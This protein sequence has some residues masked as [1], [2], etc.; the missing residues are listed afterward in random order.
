MP[1]A[2]RY[3]EET[4]EVTFTLTEDDVRDLRAGLMVGDEQGMTSP[5]VRGHSVKQWIENGLSV[6]Y[7]RN[8]MQLMGYLGFL[9]L[10]SADEHVVGLIHDLNEAVMHWYG[11][12]SDDDQT[13]NDL[14]LIDMARDMIDGLEDM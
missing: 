2:I 10:S 9:V 3:N 14:E 6:K 13:V 5:E 7:V 8:H 12:C 11:V 1:N 4:H